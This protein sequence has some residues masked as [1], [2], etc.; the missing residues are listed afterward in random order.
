MNIIT[1][2]KEMFLSP[3]CLHQFQS[4]CTSATKRTT[5]KLAHETTQ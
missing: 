3:S 5:K 1:S 2:R 4:A